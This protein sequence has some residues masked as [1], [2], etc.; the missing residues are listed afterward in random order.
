MYVLVYNSGDPD[1]DFDRFTDVGCRED[2]DPPV[3]FR[4]SNTSSVFGCGQVLKFDRVRDVVLRYV[5][6][7]TDG[8]SRHTRA[9]LYNLSSQMY[10]SLVSPN[11]TGLSSQTGRHDKSH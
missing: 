5:Q 8:T 2:D 11:M 3:V 9:K 10:G 6:D 7:L 1:T 4:E